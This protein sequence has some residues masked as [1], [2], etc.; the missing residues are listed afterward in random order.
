M[1]IDLAF[2]IGWINW[3]FVKMTRIIEKHPEQI[4]DFQGDLK[5]VFLSLVEIW[6]GV[7]T[8]KGLKLITNIAA[9]IVINPD[10]LKPVRKKM[11]DMQNEWLQDSEMETG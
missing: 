10:P 5:D 11:N 6:Q 2:Y 3:A 4:A 8:G 7:P 1:K 9:W